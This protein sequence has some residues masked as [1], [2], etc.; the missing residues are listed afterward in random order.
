[1]GVRNPAIQEP[2][3]LARLERANLLVARLAFRT[4]EIAR[5]L[6]LREDG[7]RGGRGAGSCSTSRKAT[8]SATVGRGFRK[9]LYDALLGPRVLDC[10]AKAIALG[11]DEAE[12][13][14]LS[15]IPKSR[16]EVVPNA[17]TPF[18]PMPRDAV[19]VFRNVHSIDPETGVVGYLGRL[20]QSKGLDLL[21]EAAAAMA[22][23]TRRFALLL[24]GPDDGMGPH[25]RQKAAD[26]GIASLVRFTGF[27]AAETR[28]AALQASD[29]LVIPR[30]TGSPITI[31]EAYLLE[32]P[33][34]T[35]ERS[36]RLDWLTEAVARTTQF[37][38]G[39]LA[40]AIEEL[41]MSPEKRAELG[42][43]GRRAVLEQ[44]S[45]ETIG[46][47]YESLY[48][49]CIDEARIARESRSK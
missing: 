32:R 40:R 8:G 30:F 17:L 27:L 23:S 18:S 49:G 20:H 43:A 39:P 21:L 33:V 37:K 25:L 35:T 5:L 6:R 7:R 1:M 45:W 34:I 44:F 3:Q 48:R 26:L 22:K 24:A 41:L 46:K 15:G 29:V 36:D 10:I 42:A 9:K 13:Y 38:A 4:T 16:V 2:E 12:L 14:T 28:L 47:R 19:D 11:P 31:L